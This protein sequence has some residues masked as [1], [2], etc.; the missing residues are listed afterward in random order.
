MRP[1]A[2]KSRKL[3]RWPRTDTPIPVVAVCVAVL[4]LADGVA[5]AWLRT[6]LPES[7]YDVGNSGAL[8]AVTAF[9]VALTL[10]VSRRLAVTT[11]LLVLL[12]ETAGYY[13]YL[14]HVEDLRVYP[15]DVIFWS[16]AALSVGPLIGQAAYSVR[17]GSGGQRVTAILA[18]CGVVVGAGYYW[19]RGVD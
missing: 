15:V 18:L 9:A 8:W 1:P 16:V 10:G 17:R 14:P 3:N 11:G 19:L 4:G 12:G 2:L 13:S 7:F 6:V 5:T